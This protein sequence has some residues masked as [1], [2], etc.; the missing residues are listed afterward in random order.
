MY[1][2]WDIFN[3]VPG[4]CKPFHLEI[5]SSLSGIHLNEVFS[6]MTLQ[7]FYLLSLTLVFFVFSNFTSN[8]IK[9]SISV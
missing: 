8:S 2:V 4:T 1:F 3:T 5:I 9:F 7:L 6:R